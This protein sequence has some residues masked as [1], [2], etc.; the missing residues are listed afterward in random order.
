MTERESV[1]TA[2]I[3]AT[4]RGTTETMSRKMKKNSSAPTPAIA[5]SMLTPIS[6]GS[7][8]ATP[9]KLDAAPIRETQ[10][11]GR[12]FPSAMSERRAEVTRMVASVPRSFSPATDSSVTDMHEEKMNTTMRKGRK[13][14]IICMPN[15]SVS[16]ISLAVS[17][18]GRAQLANTALRMV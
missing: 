7:E 2:A 6:V 14:D 9:R 16:P 10:A 13:P 8:S 3:A 18:K 15:A 17:T 4:M 11:R 12:I 1:E 5:T